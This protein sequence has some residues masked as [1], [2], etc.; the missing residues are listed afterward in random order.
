MINYK[1]FKGL[2]CEQIN[3]MQDSIRESAK[4]LGTRPEF[5]DMIKFEECYIN[6]NLLHW[7]YSYLKGFSDKTR[8]EAMKFLIESVAMKVYCKK[9]IAH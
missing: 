9:R 3:E 6:L 2:T 1:R 4:S 8:K 7:K 5:K